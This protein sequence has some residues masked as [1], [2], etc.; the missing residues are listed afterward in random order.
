[1]REQSESGVLALIGPWGSGKSS[2]LE[3]TIQHLENAVSGTDTNGCSVAE[4]SPWLYSDLESLTLTVALFG[5]IRA[6]LPEGAS[7]RIA[8]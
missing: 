7:G 6:A 8:E 4:L 2:V 5:E 1:V 3:M